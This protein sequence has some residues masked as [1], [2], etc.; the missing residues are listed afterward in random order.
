MLR[1]GSRR[2][3][4]ITGLAVAALLA[5]SALTGCAKDP[6]AGGSGG[7]N[8]Q[9]LTVGLT[10]IPNIQFAPFYVA[11]EK[12]YY[13]QAGLKVDL[14]HHSASE[15]LFGALNSG[16]EDVVY[17]GGDEMMQAQAQSKPIVDVAT[18]Y[19][20]YPVALLVPTDSAIHS[21]NDL[22]GHVLGTPG[23]YGETY[24]GLLALLRSAN[25]STKD[26]KVKYIGFTQQAALAGKKVDGVMGFVNNDAV[27]FDQ[28][29]IP[30]RAVTATDGGQQPPLVGSGLGATRTTLQNRGAQIKKFLA[31]TMRGVQETIDNPQEAVQLSEKYVPD[32]QDPEQQAAALSVLKATI[33]LVRTGSGKLGYND[34]ATWARMAEFMKQQ[35]LL[36]HPVSTDQAFSDSYLP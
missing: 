4:A 7:K 9:Q 28:A 10:Y 18:L 24:F 26:V 36:S 2:L 22:R 8:S 31:A 30:V 14:R 29:H 27:Q 13:Q 6:T 34:P 12:G 19:Q 15:D 23:P 21:A 25:L 17:A 33:P 35:G 20:K 5:G 11:E 32:L 1:N 16:R 3:R